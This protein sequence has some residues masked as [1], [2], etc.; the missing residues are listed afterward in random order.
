MM[1]RK[2]NENSPVITA[3]QKKALEAL[4]IINEQMNKNTV[5]INNCAWF[6]E[7]EKDVT[8]CSDTLK[9][10]TDSM[11]VASKELS[12]I[13][14]ARDR[15]ETTATRS[16]AESE[17]IA[18]SKLNE[19]ESLRA[20]G[21]ILY[22]LFPR[23]FG[24]NISVPIDTY[25]SD[26]ET[27]IKSMQH[28]KSH[29]E[30]ALTKAQEAQ[31]EAENALN[32]LPVVQDHQAAV[33]NRDKA[34]L[35]AATNKEVIITSCKKLFDE[36]SDKVL[37]TDEDKQSNVTK[38]RVVSDMK[39]FVENPTE[40]T[41]AKFEESAADFRAMDQTREKGLVEYFTS[42]KVMS[43]YHAIRQQIDKCQALYEGQIDTNKPIVSTQK[44]QTEDAVLT[45]S[46]AANMPPHR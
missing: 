11:Q 33:S 44:S 34:N 3:A 28:E 30:K 45:L 24:I 26:K 6:E 8:V 37:R 21:I 31:T 20:V 32:R 36:L 14:K 25:I 12:E 46:P 42:S 27:A 40:R 39:N 7:K 17:T 18:L 4:H 5:Y 9:A 23:L 35:E 16:A 38:I 29:A 2:K 10:L 1:T 22:Y 13:I 15:G 43:T 19:G 41:K